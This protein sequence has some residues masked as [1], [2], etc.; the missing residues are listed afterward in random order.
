MQRIW[1]PWRMDYIQGL[2]EEH[3]A[4]E[5]AKGCIFCWKPREE[6]A[7][8]AANLIVARRE[9]CFV[10]MNLYPYNN[11]HLMVVPYRHT[12]DFTSLDD[13]EL[14][15]CQR[16]VKD[17]VRAMEQSLQ[18]QGW[19]IGLN[20]GKAGGAGIDQHLHWHVVPRWVGDTNFFPVLGGVKVISESMEASWQ[21]MHE[22]FSRL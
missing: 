15:D 19:N 16:A 2:N 20:L 14:L 3:A 9:H 21:R 12:C 11:S 4:A 5:A 7:Q 1:A 10:I 22:A 6:P 17:A 8:D 18:P 13:A